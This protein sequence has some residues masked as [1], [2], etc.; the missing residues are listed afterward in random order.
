M[1]TG[2][3]R[4]VGSVTEYTIILPWGTRILH[5]NQCL[6]WAE[7][8]RRVQAVRKTVYV[9]ALLG[10]YPKSVP[11]A[12]ITLTWHPPRA[13]RTDAENLAPLLKACVDGLALG[14]GKTLGYGLT[15]DDTPQY[16]TTRCVIGE[17]IPQGKLLLHI[18]VPE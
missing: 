18:E 12:T 1:A 2:T 15:A 9:S 16:V 13:Y 7:H 4:Q 5:A 6:H 3:L 17:P 14:T 10:K 11:H 8:N